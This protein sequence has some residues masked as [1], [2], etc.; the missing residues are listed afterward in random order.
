MPPKSNQPRFISI[1]GNIGSG[2][3]TVLQVIRE[4]FPSLTILDEPLS[5]WQKVGANQN[6][7]LLGMYYQD[8]KRWGFTFQ[9]YAFMTRLNKWREYSQLVGQGIRISER[10]LL[11]DRYIFASIMRDTHLLD[12]AEHSIYLHFYDHLVRINDIVDL[13]GVIYIRCPPE[14]CAER[15]KK[16]S[17]EGEDSIPLDYLSKIHEKH[18]D[19]L[20]RG[21]TKQDEKVLV[22]DNSVKMDRQQIV[23]TISNWL[24]RKQVP[25]AINEEPQVEICI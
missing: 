21:E 17:R 8:P 12:E 23:D 11:S 25:L 4:Q 10:S 14:I 5:E 16:R 13:Y 18:E 2:K 6:I 15:I 9:I 24:A 22:I 19:W 20:V 7:N 3:S 1:E